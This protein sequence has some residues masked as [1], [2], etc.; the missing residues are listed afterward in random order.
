MSL[1]IASLAGTGAG[2]GAGKFL[3][4]RA[5]STFQVPTSNLFIRG[6]KGPKAS[7]HAVIDEPMVETI[8]TNHKSLYDVLNVKCNATPFEIKGAYRC[9]AK[10]Y[11]PDANCDMDKNKNDGC[12]FIDI[13]NAYVTLSDPTT[14]ALYDMKIRRGIERR[15]GGGLY[16]SNSGFCTGRRWET[17]QCW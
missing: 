15:S 8:K 14:R 3:N 17:D 7:M 13:H 12:D 10:R 6:R 11:H 16:A 2:A 4:G 1:T 9:M 5:Q